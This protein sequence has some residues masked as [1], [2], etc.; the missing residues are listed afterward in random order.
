MH[1]LLSLLAAVVLQDTASARLVLPA[2]AQDSASVLTFDAFYAKVLA[3]NPVVRQARLLD[4]VGRAEVL[5]AK[6]GVYDP[7]V[8]ALWAKKA[9]ASA[10]YYNYLDAALK[11]PTPVGIDFKL[12]YE[13]TS[14]TF[15]N[16]D[17]TTPSSGLLSAGVVI[18]LGRGLITDSRRNALA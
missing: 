9:F 4:D 16:P 14:G 6:G 3:D 1:A 7:T 11:I 18:P 12:G 15:V 5:A 10:G 13:Q 17:R 8:S 2:A